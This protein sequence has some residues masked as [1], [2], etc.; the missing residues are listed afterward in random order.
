MSHSP[1]TLFQFLEG[2]DV[3]IW[4]DCLTSGHH[5]HQNC[6]INVP[7][8]SDYELSSRRSCL[9]LLLSWWLRMMPLHWLPFHL[10]LIVVSPG[11]ITC[12]DPGKKRLPPQHQMLQQFRTVGFPLT[13]LLGCETLRNPS[14]AYLRIS[15]SVN[16]CHCTSIADWK[17]YGQLLTCDA[18]IH[19]NNAIGVLQHVLAGG[20]GR[21]PRPWSIMQL[22][23]STSWSLNSL[24]PVSNGAPI[25]STTSIY[26][27]NHLWMFPTLSFSTTKN[28]ITAH[29]L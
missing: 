16:N 27:T 5:I 21:T 18:P 14:C 7:K 25:D 6:S 15:Q 19:M 23:F 10:R 28:S 3:R 22:R 29:C 12:D 1:V 2:F 9:E 13:S 24:N 20:C 8:D 4:I 11:F 17:V 26:S